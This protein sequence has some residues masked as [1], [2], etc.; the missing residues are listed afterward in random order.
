[1]EKELS[2]LPKDEDLLDAQIWEKVLFF[3][4]IGQNGQRVLEGKISPFPIFPY[5]QSSSSSAMFRDGPIKIPLKY[6]AGL[7]WLTLW[8]WESIRLVLTSSTREEDWQ[9][10]R[11]SILHL[12]LQI[13]HFLSEAHKARDD[14]PAQADWRCPQFDVLLWRHLKGGHLSTKN[15][16][17]EH[18]NLYQARVTESERRNTVD[19]RRGTQTF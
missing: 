19:S 13:Q 3:Y 14:I 15:G 18:Y 7:L 9:T 2:W 16:I 6:R 17:V 1:M 10:F 4:S 5:G 8:M 11:L 12:A